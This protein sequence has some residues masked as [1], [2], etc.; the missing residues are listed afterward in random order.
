M[1]QSIDIQWK[2]H[3]LEMDHIKEGIGMRGYGQRDPLI[4]YKKEGFRL[5]NEL[6]SR[7]KEQTIQHLFMVQEYREEEERE[8][9]RRIK[10]QREIDQAA[11]AAGSEKPVPVQRKQPKVGRNDPCICGSGKKYKKCC[12]Q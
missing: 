3:L 2:D 6:I 1:L 9:R 7:I 12:G 4:E 8:R 11:H 5:F 10:V